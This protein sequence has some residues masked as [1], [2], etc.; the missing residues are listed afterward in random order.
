MNPRNPRPPHALGEAPSPRPHP[1]PSI[2]KPHEPSLIQLLPPPLPRPPRPAP[3]VAVTALACQQVSWRPPLLHPA[4]SAPPSHLLHMMATHPGHGEESPKA[5]PGLPSPTSP[6]Q[7]AG[8]FWNR[9]STCC[10]WAALSLF[11]SLEHSSRRY[12]FLSA[13]LLFF[14]EVQCTHHEFTLS[15][16]TVPWLWG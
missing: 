5:S 1:D 4:T 9:P 8:C 13:T 10:L 15:K 16:C 7:P 12:A 11:L 14:I 3:E 6:K 2:S